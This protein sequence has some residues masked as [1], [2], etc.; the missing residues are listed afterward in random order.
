MM[1]IKIINDD[2]KWNRYLST[3]SYRVFAEE[4]GR[5][6]IDTLLKF[7]TL[8]IKQEKYFCGLSNF[9]KVPKNSINSQFVFKY[10]NYF[11]NFETYLH[12]PSTFL[13]DEI[14]IFNKGMKLNPMFEKYN[15]PLIEIPV[16]TLPKLIENS[17][18]VIVVEN[19]FSE[20]G[21]S[22]IFFESKK[23]K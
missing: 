4:N 19:H 2:F 18:L 20:F 1:D 8:E 10:G 15:R 5:R 13:L 21:A 6:S 17:E 14:E 22:I 7:A 12:N 11:Q 23:N 9:Y 3:K 16:F